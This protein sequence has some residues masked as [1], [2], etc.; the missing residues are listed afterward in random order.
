MDGDPEAFFWKSAKAIDARLK[1]YLAGPHRDK[2][3][4]D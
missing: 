4:N 3:L 1:A 2:T